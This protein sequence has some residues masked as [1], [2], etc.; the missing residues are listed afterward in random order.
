[1]PHDNLRLALTAGMIALALAMP[2]ASPAH[3]QEQPLLMDGKETL[4]QRVLVRERTIG[5]DGPDGAEVKQLAPLQ[6]LYVYSREGDWLQ[7][8]LND[9]GGPFVWMPASAAT[10]W[11]Q[12][13]VATLESSEN[14]GRLLFFHDIDPIFDVIESENPGRDAQALREEALEA[15]R[16]GATSETIVALGPRR[17]IDQKTNLYVMPIL[18]FEEGIF[19]SGAFVNLLKVAVAR[20]QPEGVTAPQAPPRD[21][22]LANYRAGVVFVVDTTVSMDPY[23]DATQAALAQVYQEI[24]NAGAADAVSFGLI[25]YRDS[26]DAAPE[27]EYETRT[28]VTLREGSRRDIFLNAIGSMEE[29][30]ASSRN[31]R[32]DSYAG[33][34]HALL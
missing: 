7:V 28:F 12:T 16:G 5:R 32:E 2:L 22:G 11:N 8:G 15:E 34:E 10:D 24:E 4:F 20:A 21:S 14:V 6:P 9:T 30:K 17:G 26:L 33:I 1:M 3:A 29:A 23:I 13:I 18:D 19:D 25:G 31:F 27:L